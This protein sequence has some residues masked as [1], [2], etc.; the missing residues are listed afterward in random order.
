MLEDA[1]KQNE[2]GNEFQYITSDTPQQKVLFE[3]LSITLCLWESAIVAEPW[4]VY[5][6][7]TSQSLGRICNHSNQGID[8]VLVNT[9]KS[10]LNMV[11]ILARGLF[12]SCWVLY[13]GKNKKGASSQDRRN[14]NQ[15]YVPQRVRRRENTHA[16]CSI[17]DL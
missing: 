6:E 9:G 11:Q 16:R 12:R 5:H 4:R 14:K 7:E 13:A 3:H 10:A 2:V 17:L 15:K 8:Q 1:C